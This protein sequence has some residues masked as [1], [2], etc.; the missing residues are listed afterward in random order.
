MYAYKYIQNVYSIRFVM[1]GSS[2]LGCTPIRTY[3][4]TVA[5]ISVIHNISPSRLTTERIK[6]KLIIMWL[7]NLKPRLVY[8]G[9]G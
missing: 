2:W 7:T 5:Y 8:R 6:K 9:A 3:V 4:V 1:Y